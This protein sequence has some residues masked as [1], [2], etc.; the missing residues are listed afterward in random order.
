MRGCLWGAL[1]T[2]AVTGPIV[3]PVLTRVRCG[4]S[5]APTPSFIHPLQGRVSAVT[6]RKAL[7]S[8]LDTRK[9]SEANSDPTRGA[10]ADPWKAPGPVPT[11][12][13]G[14]SRAER[15]LRGRWGAGRAGRP[16]QLLR[17]AGRRRTCVS[18]GGRSNALVLSVSLPPLPPPSMFRPESLLG[19]KKTRVPGS[20]NSSVANW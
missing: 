4:S 10:S 14:L 3:F 17:S 19:P 16:S 9:R 13:T 6:K 8:V 15:Q 20:V 12:V 1:S 11:V 5:H 18:R 7:Y 2:S